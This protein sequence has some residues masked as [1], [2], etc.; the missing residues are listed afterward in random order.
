MAV[1]RGFDLVEVSPDVVP[2]VCKLMDYGRF[3]YESRKKSQKSKKKLHVV[4]LKELRLRPITE[5]HDVMVKIKHAREI[6]AHGDK[7][8]F[9]LFF[10]GRE[11]V[12]LDI[13]LK[14]LERIQTE[15]A[16]VAK[17]EGSFQRMGSRMFLTMVKK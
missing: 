6:L 17:P 11:I 1:E 14:V 10:K 2:P 12:H 9:S 8:L 5:E 13:G 4:R 16:D 7:V 15:L 3:K